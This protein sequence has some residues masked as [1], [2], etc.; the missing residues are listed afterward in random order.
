MTSI[1]SPAYTQC[2]PQDG[3][4]N[5][6]DTVASLAY[7]ATD[8]TNY[9]Y[10]RN[11]SS[12]VVCKKDH[13]GGDPAPHHTKACY[14]ATI[15]ADFL[16]ADGSYYD[17][18]TGDPIGNGWQFCT[19]GGKNNIC[20]PSGDIPVDM[21]YGS[22]RSFTYANASSVPCNNDIFGG[23][24]DG[25]CFWRMPLGPPGPA[26]AGGGGAPSNGGGGA[27]SNGGGAPSNGGG[28]TS[29]PTGSKTGLYVG[30]GLGLLLFLIIIIVLIVLA[31]KRKHKTV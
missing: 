11:L 26:P 5:F 14:K 20:K 31:M 23:P 1:V 29:T 19:A 4:C 2:A 9:P 21:L 16:N 30:L 7:A 28:G 15:P 8:G 24:S 18:S 25:N 17:T 10:Y 6:T 27:P 12:P 13:F 3:T 22:D